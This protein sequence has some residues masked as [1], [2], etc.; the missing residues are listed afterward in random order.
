[1]KKAL[2]I[3]VNYVGTQNELRGCINDVNNFYT[4][5]TTFFGYEQKNIVCLTENLDRTN[6]P[7]KQNIIDGINWLLLNQQAG[8]TL[9]FYYSG[10][11]SN[12][13]DFSNDE[14]DG[15]DEVIIP[16]DFSQN[17]VIPDDWLNDNLVEK[18]NQSVKFYSFFDSCNSG[19]VLDLKCNLECDTRPLLSLRDLRRINRYV[20]N[21]WTNNFKILYNNDNNSTRHRY[22]FSACLSN[23]YANETSIN[24]LQQGYFS[25]FL[26]E[27]LRKNLADNNMKCTLKNKDIVKAINS[28]LF[29]NNMDHQ[30][31]MLSVCNIADIDETFSL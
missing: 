23:E 1:M 31:C 28:N 30:N 13:Q 26:Q 22:C 3:G 2:L 4:L 10:H 5:L 20:S 19:T 27:V 18:V 16:L 15:K 21:F 12:M 7:T 14:Q 9:T 11:G 6:H 17:G 25:Y 29:M 8:D 24:N